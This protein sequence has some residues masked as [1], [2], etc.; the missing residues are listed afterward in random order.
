MAERSFGDNDSP[1]DGAGR[2]FTK[3]PNKSATDDDKARYALQ[4]WKKQRDHWLGLYQIWAKI[5]LFIMGKHWHL[6]NGQEARWVPEKHIPRW[7]QRPC[8]P[9]TFAVFRTFLA[10]LTKQRPTY[11]VAPPSG[12]QADRDSAAL[13]ESI[14]QSLWRTLKMDVL[15]RKLIAWLFVTATAYVEV[16]WDPDGGDDQ[17]LTEKVRHP[18]TG[19][20]V[21]C[22]CDEDGEP[23]LKKQAIP[24]IPGME[25]QVP[26]EDA[27]PA[28]VR[29]GEIGLALINPMSIRFNPDANSPDEAY[30]WFVGEM[31]PKQQ[32]ADEFK[33]D[34]NEMLT[35][36][37]E[38]MM[39]VQDQL[40][41]ATATAQNQFNVWGGDRR[42]AIG[43][44]VL[45][46]RYY[47]KP[48][49]DFPKGRH[50]IQVGFQMTPDGEKDLPYGF[51]PPFVSIEDVPIAGQPT[52]ASL[53]AQVVPLNEQYN[54]ITAKIRE[55]QLL[56][57]MGGKY[58]VSPNNAK[59][60]ITSDPGQVVVDVDFFRGPSGGIEQL[61]PL[62]LP[63]EVYQERARIVE[64][65]QV[66]SAMSEVALGTRPEGTPSG[67]SILASQESSD[68][69]LG[70]TLQ[71]L[72][73]GFEEI[74]RRMLVIARAYYEE[75]RLIKIRGENGEWQIKSFM[76]ADLGTTADVRVQM[77]SMFPWSKSARIDTAIQLLSSLPQLVVNPQ[78]GEVNQ[79]RLAKFLDVGGLQVF[80]SD[81]DPDLVE[82]NREH[83]EFEAYSPVT[84]WEPDPI[85]GQAQPPALGFWQDAPKHLAEHQNFLKRDAARFRAWHP[86][87][88]H[89][90]LSHIL[91]TIQQIQGIVQQTMPGA[92]GMAGE[93]PSAAGQQAPPGAGGPGG[94]PGPPPPPGGGGAPPGATQPIGDNTGAPPTHLTPAD[95][96]S[97][98][99]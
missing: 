32:A 50:W 91:Q 18:L 19:E 48:D 30:E 10:K 98:G 6:W 92:D 5:I 59:V 96:A 12:D 46:L 65:L 93:P 41:D 8:I 33:M 28:L 7:R 15:L 82:I 70:P 58:R 49:A 23:I 99:G 1:Y 36:S 55:H 84:G 75:K 3:A 69:V 57:A 72:E 64:D 79:E 2:L 62:P 53:G 31:W 25:F 16:R 26:D 74:G 76:G 43:P 68:S 89:A 85:T 94:P 52:G 67:R 22:P 40:H 14:L 80:Q 9:W 71:S 39:Q 21:D 51:W 97:A 38:D 60:K 37:D 61:K 34:I 47:C 78:S 27:K 86:D 95:M 24:E 77:G 4:R 73:S 87:A 35:S 42:G 17:E 44:R 54:K 13:S 29:K 66:V 83:A 88:Q 20:L 63:A 90:F 45:V 11:E 56:M 81:E